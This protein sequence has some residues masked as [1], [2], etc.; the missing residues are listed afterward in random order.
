MNFVAAWF[1]ADV[2]YDVPPTSSLTCLNL[3]G[4]VK[5]PFVSRDENDAVVRPLPR[6]KRTL[7][8]AICLPHV[9]QV[10]AK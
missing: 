5:N 3:T 8:E 4:P 9:V 10:G 6:V 7:S 2:R 1:S